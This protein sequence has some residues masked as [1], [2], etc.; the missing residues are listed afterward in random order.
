MRSLVPIFLTVL[1]AELGDKTQLAT[2]LFATDPKL[3]RVGVF[4]AAASALTVSSL[5]AV[6]FGA[7]LTR[8]VSP[9]LLETL[10]A[11]GFIMIGLWMLLAKYW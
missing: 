6:A 5:L 7:Q 8:L 9:A 4:I 10:A 11:I 1:L 3:S 2:L